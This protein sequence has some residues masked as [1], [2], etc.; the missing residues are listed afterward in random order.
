MSVYRCWDL[1]QILSERFQE[2]QQAIA[3]M[4]SAERSIHRHDLFERFFLHSEIRVNVDVGG[5]DTFVTQ[6][7]RNH[8]DIDSTFK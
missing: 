7:E 6:P 4:E 8:G 3:G 2:R 1:E 5:L